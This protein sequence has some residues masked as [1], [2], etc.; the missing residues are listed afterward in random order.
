MSG[1]QLDP[2]GA[3]AVLFEDVYLPAFVEKCAAL[4]LSF[5]DQASL[6]SALESVAMLKSAETTE[7]VDLTKSAAADL[8]SAMGVPQPEDTQR[9]AE[10]Q[11]QAAAQA[12]SDRVRGAI[13]AL[14]VSQG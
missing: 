7:T 13:D 1:T 10:E 3:Q 12:Q 6:Q 9:A 14:I 11:K 8:R 2:A 4:G 5:N